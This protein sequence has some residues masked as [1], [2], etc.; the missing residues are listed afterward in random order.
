[1]IIEKGKEVKSEKGAIRN[2]T[3]LTQKGV[4][5]PKSLF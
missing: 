4:S 1:V 5:L 2:G 3:D